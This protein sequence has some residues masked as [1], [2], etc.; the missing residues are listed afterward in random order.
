MRTGREILEFL[1]VFCN[2][3]YWSVLVGEIWILAPSCLVWEKIS[4]V[5]YV[6]CILLSFP[7]VPLLQPSGRA[8]LRLYSE[9]VTCCRLEQSWVPAWVL[10]SVMTTLPPPS[11]TLRLNS[12]PNPPAAPVIRKFPFMALVS[13]SL[14]LRVFLE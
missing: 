10:V 14:S 6:M 8:F 13:V 11:S 3:I 5:F 2:R 9:G 1:I 7:T 12:A 4:L